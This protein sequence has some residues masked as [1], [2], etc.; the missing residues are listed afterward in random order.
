MDIRKP[1]GPDGKEVEPKVHFSTGLSRYVAFSCDNGDGLESGA[2]MD[3]NSHPAHFDAV[4]KPRSKEAE[5]LLKEFKYS[6]G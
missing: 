3:V 5:R 2:D 6:S 4:F 1:I